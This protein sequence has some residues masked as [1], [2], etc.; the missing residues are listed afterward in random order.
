[1]PVSVS[2]GLKE[3]GESGQRPSPFADQ[4]TQVM[5]SGMLAAWLLSAG[6]ANRFS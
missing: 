6:S 1:M 4:V 3:V 2:K 5:L